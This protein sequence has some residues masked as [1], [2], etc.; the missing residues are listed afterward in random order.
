MNSSSKSSS[1]SS[2][3]KGMHEIARR[4]IGVT[5]LV[6]REVLPYSG[7]NDRHLADH[8]AVEVMRDALNN[9]PYRTEILIGEGEK[10]EAPMLY[11]GHLA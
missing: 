10:D 8:H 6:A 1:K 7:K 4:F 5:D 2:S 3:M 9:L 11:A